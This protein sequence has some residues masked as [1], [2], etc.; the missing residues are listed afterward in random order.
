MNRTELPVTKYHGCG[1]D[2][3]IVHARD[4]QNLDWPQ[5][6]VA[7]CDRHTGI[8]ADGFIVVCTDPLEMVYYNQ[9]GSRAPMCGNGIRCFSAFCLNA[10]RFSQISL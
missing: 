8:G 7:L 6:A 1:N 3:V 4:V 2:F 10:R 5:L 9:D